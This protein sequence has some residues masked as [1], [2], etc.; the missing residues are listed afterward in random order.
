MK[1]KEG[2]NNQTIEIDLKDM[3]MKILM[4]MASN[5]QKMRKGLESILIR[6]NP[7]I[8]TG[9]PQISKQNLTQSRKDTHHMPH[10]IDNS[11]IILDETCIQ[12]RTKNR[13]NKAIRRKIA[14]ICH[15]S[16]DI[17]RMKA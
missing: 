14:E 3:V 1:E 6:K 13:K 15:F 12:N 7:T 5:L 4:M 8:M 10:Y 2:S 11:V 9:S 17:G 16:S